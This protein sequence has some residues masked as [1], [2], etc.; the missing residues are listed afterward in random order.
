LRDR[1][2]HAPGLGTVDPQPHR[3]TAATKLEQVLEK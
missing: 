1:Y 2:A 3:L